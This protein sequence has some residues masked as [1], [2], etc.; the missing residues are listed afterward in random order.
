MLKRFCSTFELQM[1]YFYQSEKPLD[2]KSNFCD[3]FTHHFGE[4]PTTAYYLSININL[5]NVLSSNYVPAKN[6]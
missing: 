6:M 5:E 2:M 1:K 3:T 4:Q